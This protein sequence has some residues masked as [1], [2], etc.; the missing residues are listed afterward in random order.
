MV[1]EGSLPGGQLQSF[2]PFWKIYCCHISLHL[3]IKPATAC[4]KLTHVICSL[5]KSSRSGKNQ[6]KQQTEFARGFHSS[7]PVGALFFL[8]KK[9]YRLVCVIY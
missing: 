8:I 5:G 1:L 4:D 3:S 2:N 9:K 6:L 7:V